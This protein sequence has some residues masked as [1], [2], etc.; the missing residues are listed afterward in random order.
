MKDSDFS[1]KGKI[2]IYVFCFQGVLY[3][4]LELCPKSPFLFSYSDDQ[5]NNAILIIFILFSGNTA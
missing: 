5:Q 1:E 4:G 2:F 3:V